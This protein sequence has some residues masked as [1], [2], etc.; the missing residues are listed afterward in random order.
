MSDCADAEQTLPVIFARTAKRLGDRPALVDGKAC[1]ITFGELQRRVEALSSAWRRQ[2]LGH[3][4]RVL[5]AMPLG[6]DLYASLAAIWTLGAVAV[7]PEPAMGLKGVAAAI[8]GTPLH[9]T[10]ASGG[11][12]LLRYLFPGLLGKPLYQPSAAAPRGRAETVAAMTGAATTGAGNRADNTEDAPHL[13]EGHRGAAGQPDDLALISFT[14]GTTGTPKAVPRSHAFLMAQYQAVDA[15]LAGDD[16]E[17]DLV[18]FPVFALANLAAGRT[19]VLPSWPMRKHH[20]VTPETLAAQLERDGITRALL[21]PTLAERLTRINRSGELHT[22]FTGGGPVFPDTLERLR[23]RLPR[24][25]IV[26]VYGST[27]AE[28]IAELDVSEMTADDVEAMQGG[29]GL[30]VG[31]PC[32]GAEVRIGADRE[33]QVAGPHVNR[34][35]LDPSRNAETKVVEGSRVWHRTGDAGYLDAQGRLWLLGRVGEV[36]A[37]RYP[38]AIEAVARRWPGVEQAAL[39]TSPTGEGAVLVLQGTRDDTLRPHAQSLGLHQLLWLDAIPMDRRH[40]SR[41]DRNRL[42]RIVRRRC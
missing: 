9:G 1:V 33:I 24:A 38:L 30:L 40:R 32:R 34:G 2:G 3:G 7:L 39:M 35:Y 23:E 25:R 22:V 36:I 41:I 10:C 37:E 42:A 5:V 15:L 21:P 6:I 16:N 27:E 26:C 17:R 11:Y 19:S 12:R 18:A 4:D 8:R 20:R 14:S 31:N 28:P 13:S 29:A